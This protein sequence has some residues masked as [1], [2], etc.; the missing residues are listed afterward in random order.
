MPELLWL[1]SAFTMAASV[2]RNVVLGLYRDLLKTASTWE[3][4]NFREYIKRRVKED[5]A[6]HKH[7]T[8]PT[9]LQ[10]FVAAARE[11][12]SIVKRQGT[13]QNMYNQDKLV[14]EVK[15]SL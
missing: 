1:I 6:A 5:F 2:S 13:I 4:Y 7:E 12:L 3:N 14:L 9:R 10:A 11:N 8:D 15:K